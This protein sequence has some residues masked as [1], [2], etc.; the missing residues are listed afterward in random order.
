MLQLLVTILTTPWAISSTSM[1]GHVSSSGTH[2][3]PKMI[4]IFEVAKDSSW[5]L[6]WR[7]QGPIVKSFERTL[8]LHWEMQ[9]CLLLMRVEHTNLLYHDSED[10]DNNRRHWDDLKRMRH[11]KRSP[12]EQ[13]EEMIGPLPIFFAFKYQSTLLSHSYANHRTIFNWRKMVVFIYPISS[14]GIQYRSIFNFQ[15]WSCF[16]PKRWVMNFCWILN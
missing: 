8:T 13:P 16:S 2:Q 15:W 5:V 6:T 7:L 4:L 9:A 1:K 12:L 14:Q 10:R 11:G 3:A